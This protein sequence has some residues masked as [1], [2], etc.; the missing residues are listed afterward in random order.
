MGI[1]GV[2]A[3]HPVGWQYYEPAAIKAAIRYGIP[4]DMFMRLLHVEN[5][6]GDPAAVNPRSGAAGLG[7][8]VPGTAAHLSINPLDPHVSLNAAAQYLGSLR[9]EFPDWRHAV[10]AYNWGP[11]NVRR[12]LDNNCA[13]E[14]PAETVAYLSHIKP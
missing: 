8:F 6:A 7:Q 2:A 12:W 1:V 4:P 11:G 10:M 14:L 5:P 9:Q 13:N 3:V